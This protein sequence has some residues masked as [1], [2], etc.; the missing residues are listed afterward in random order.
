MLAR[1][2]VLDKA[3]QNASGWDV[4]GMPPRRDLLIVPGLGV[5]E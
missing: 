5:R 3:S 2:L 4:C 1:G